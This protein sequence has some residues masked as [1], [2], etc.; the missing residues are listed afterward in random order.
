MRRHNSQI[1]ALAPGTNL[2]LFLIILYLSFSLIT[3]AQAGEIVFTRLTKESGLSA[4]HIHYIIKDKQGY[5]WLSSVN[6]LQRY[7][8]Y[9][10]INFNH[11]TNDSNSLP[12]NNVGHLMEDRQKRLWVDAGGY[13]C[14]YNPIKRSFKKIPVASPAKKKFSIG[15]FFQDSKG[16]IW[17]VAKKD[18]LF[19][20]DTLNNI[21]RP[22]STVWPHFFSEAYNIRED[23]VTGRYWLLIE[24]GTYIMYDSK[25]KKYHSKRNNP[26]RLSCFE[27]KYFDGFGG[28]LY[29]DKDRVLWAWGWVTAKGVMSFRYDIKKNELRFIYD[30]FAQNYGGFF[31]DK[32]GTTWVYGDKL[33]R[34]DTN[35]NRY[36]EVPKSRNSLYGIDFNRVHSMYE[37]A[38][39][40]LWAMTDLGLYIFNPRRQYF[41]TV[42]GVW[43]HRENKTVDAN[44]NSFLQVRD[45]NILS[46][47]WSGDG[48]IFYDSAFNQLKPLYGFGPVVKKFDFNLSMEWSGLQDSKGT[49]WIGT[50]H[51]SIIKINPETKK[52]ITMKLPEFEDHT[53]RSMVEDNM[54]NIWFGT[55]RNTLVKWDRKSDKFHKVFSDSTVKE[56]LGWLLDIL[57]GSKGDIW[58]ATGTAG[59]LH[60]DTATEKII[61]HF[62]HDENNKESIGNDFVRS[63]L[64]LNKDSLVIATEKGIDLFSISKKSF[65]H[66]SENDGLPGG[67]IISILADDKENLW[68]TTMEGIAKIHLPDKRIHKYGPLDGVTEK[69]FQYG[70]VIRLKDG[71]IVFGNT[72][73]LVYFN[74]A[75]IDEATTPSDVTITGFSIFDKSLSVDSLFQHDNKIR[76]KYAQNFINIR[77]ASLGNAIYNQPVYYYMLEGINKDWV[78]TQNHDAVYSYLPSGTYTFKVKCISLDGVECK[79]ISSFTIYI[80]PPMYLRWWFILLSLCII[81]G[82]LYYIYLLRLRRR[83]DREIIRNRIARDLHDDMGSV[84]STINILSTMTK[85]KIADD[86]VKASEYVGKI[87]DSS[88]RMME[89]MDDIVWAIK[90]DNDNMQKITARMREFATSILEAKDIELNFK[91]EEKVNDIKLN[92]EARRD[93]FLIFKEAVNNV[94]KYSRCSKCNIHIGLH[95]HRLLLDVED[96]GIGFDVGSADSGNGLSNMQKRAQ[97]LKGRANINSKPGEGTKVTL[98]VPVQ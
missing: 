77:F 91:V 13:P 90:P 93:F 31:T 59:L 74:P 4:T 5:Y 48:I 17:M 22:Y 98:N 58:V 21:F 46:I 62:R 88:Q 10:M 23:T 15:Y 43:S 32:S 95:N 76:L 86:P 57:P 24:R 50:Q 49:I 92:M 41:T 19:V 82:V 68:F 56:P 28:N 73:G 29:L 7:D 80:E 64:Q 33:G 35:L 81:A 42:S 12:D 1:S 61:D 52:V 30:L 83:N 20:L 6:G 39:G 34:Y 45:G 14:I 78:S 69:D 11:D 75:S 85:T 27:N 18:G 36:I 94:A 54:G 40:N 51:G 67:G 25:K 65:S 53:I 87:S 2:Y 89:A 9:W 8:G 70:A 72:R 3:N 26:E 37:D 66:I 16:I 71:R 47:G 63:I 44:T 38:E 60:L 84:L 55:Q 79:N 96:N 97:A